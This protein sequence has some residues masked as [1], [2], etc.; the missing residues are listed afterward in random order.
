MKIL[1][2]LAP[3]I[4]F[5]LIACQSQTLSATTIIDG[6]QIHTLITN[7]RVPRKLVIQAGI[8]LGSADRVLFNGNLVPLDQPI[9]QAKTNVLQILRAR[10]ITVNGKAIQT[11]AQT[12]GEAIA[13]TGVQI[14]A[15]DQFNPPADTPVTSGLT[16]IYTPS[17]ELTVSVDGKQIHIRSSAGTTGGA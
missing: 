4:L 9:A 14:Y 6:E 16:V 17:R 13:Q 10:T 12:V 15:A 3:T 5:F 1:R 2:W 11:T 7:E 8:V